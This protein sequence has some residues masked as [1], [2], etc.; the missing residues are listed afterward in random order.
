M[1]PDGDWYPPSGIPAPTVVDL[2]GDRRPEI[3]APVPDGA[4]Y[5]VTPTGRKLWRYDYAHGAPKT[6]ASEVVAADL[7]DDGRP[8]LVFGTYSLAAGSGRLIVLS[9]DGKLLHEL[10]LPHQA[11]DGNGVGIPAA[12]S[13]G[14]LDGDGRL[15][16]VLTSFDHGLDVFTVPGSTAIVLAV[17]HRTCQSPAQRARRRDGKVNEA[18]SAKPFRVPASETTHAL[19]AAERIPM[20]R[21]TRIAVPVLLTVCALGLSACGGSDGNDSG[22]TTAVTESTSSTETTATGDVAAGKDVFTANCGGCHT[23]ADAGTNGGV[24]PNLD[25]LAPDAQT[26]SDQVT[27]GGGSMPSFADKLSADDIANVAAY[28]SS[29]AGT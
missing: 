17:A 22:D 15:E 6:F 12:P 9:P 20:R 16:L 21:R 11:V 5:A 1:R 29:V 13:I 2:V 3:V 19:S 10:R 7:N 28:V 8:E 25:D 14:D 27:S 18:S 26:V 4:V 23:L 24:G